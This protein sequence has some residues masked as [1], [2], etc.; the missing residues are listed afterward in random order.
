MK[1]VEVIVSADGTIAI[2]AMG[3]TG[4]DCE[5]ATKFLEEALGVEGHRVRKPE[6]HARRQN[7]QH[8]QQK[9]AA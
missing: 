8:Q 5:Q 9:G 6:Y 3:F 1:S 4:P 7:H 2:D